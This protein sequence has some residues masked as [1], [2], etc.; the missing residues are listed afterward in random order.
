[1]TDIDVI[2]EQA[3][4]RWHEI[5]SYHGISVP[6]KPMEHGPCP[7]CG[8][9]DRFRLD[10]LD[11]EGTFYCNQC[12]PHA[13]DGF[14]LLRNVFGCNF[15]TALSLAQVALGY[16]PNA[17]REYRKNAKYGRHKHGVEKQAVPPDG[18]LGRSLFRYEDSDG[19]PVFYVQR[20]EHSGLKI[21][22]QWGPTSDGRGWQKNLDHL[23]G[24]KPLYRLPAI[25]ASPAEI[26]VVH[27]GE[28]AVHAHLDAGLHGVPT[29]SSGGAKAAKHTDFSTL[30]DRHVVICPDHD[31]DGERYADD[32]V[33]FARQAG[34]R[35]VRI[36][37][38]QGLPEKGDIVEWLRN[39]GTPPAFAL[40]VQSALAT[41]PDDPE[42][43]L[44]SQAEN[45]TAPW[46]VLHEAALYGLQGT[47]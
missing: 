20:I 3:R 24:P 5:L 27:E 18:E 42:D 6:N 15:V 39:G 38:L 16:R 19:N 9:K 29:T 25:V 12:L 36:L 31:Q 26:I 4:G 13:G 14:Q 30:R 21:F 22:P 41:E 33:S 40:L 1:M 47:P 8:G 34:A 10:N 2:R 17:H 32:V 7:A 23:S 44:S 35:S 28:K 45:L 37:R 43:N 11:G 46:P